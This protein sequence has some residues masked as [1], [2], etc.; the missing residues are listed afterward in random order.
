MKKDI[1][2]VDANTLNRVGI[3]LDTRKDAA[4]IARNAFADANGANNGYIPSNPESD[5]LVL[6]MDN[7]RKN[8]LAQETGRRNV[9]ITLALIDE[10]K[11]YQKGVDANGKHYT[12][13]LSLARDMFPQWAKTTITD[14]MAVG[15]KIYL[16]AAR[17]RFGAGSKIMLNQAP[18]NIAALKSV[19]ADDTTTAL[20]I[21]SIRT[22]SKA[23]GGKP[24]SQAMAKAISRNIR[25]AKDANTLNTVTPSDIIKA[26]KGDAKALSKIKPDKPETARGNV[27]QTDKQ[28]AI[29]KAAETEKYN[30]AYTKT[31]SY[32]ARGNDDSQKIVVDKDSYRGMLEKALV[33]GD[34][35]IAIR[36]LINALK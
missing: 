15:R 34:A 10:S 30:V 32:M 35:A 8:M 4:T 22:A 6:L 9:C 26:A 33:S 25:D 12:S 31:L 14:Y 20:A 7:V 5:T 29:D 19:I 3:E 11:E 28:A 18:S 2:V 23:N 36:A 17:G 24:I 13:L 21:D 1:I 27:N 16:P